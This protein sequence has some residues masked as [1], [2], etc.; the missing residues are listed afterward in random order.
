M[1]LV[2]GVSGIENVSSAVRSAGAIIA[3]RVFERGDAG[4]HSSERRESKV[5][6][7]PVF[8]RRV[9]LKVTA[10]EA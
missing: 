3:D 10:Q 8:G 7:H 6:L 2:C 9:I 5:P 1:L 4:Y